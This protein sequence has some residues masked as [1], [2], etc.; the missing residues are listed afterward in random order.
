MQFN[1]RVLDA[2]VTEA[3]VLER[4]QPTGLP[5]FFSSALRGAGVV[6]TF[7][8]LLLDTYAHLDQRYDLNRRYGLQADSRPQATPGVE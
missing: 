2:I 5:V 8:Q 6:E 1:K 7:R 3:A 4:W